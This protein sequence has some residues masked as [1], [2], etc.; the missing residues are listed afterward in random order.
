MQGDEIDELNETVTVTL[1]GATN[2]GLSSVAGA[3]TGSGTVTDDDAAELSVADV[4]VTEGSKAALT[5][6]LSVAS[7]RAVS[8]RWRT[9]SD[10]DGDH[11]AGAADYTAV[12]TLQTVTIAAGGKSASLE[13]QTTQDQVD[14]ADETFLVQLS[15]PTNAALAEA[16]AVVTITDDDAATATV[17]VG[18]PAAAVT[19][20]DDPAVTVD[21]SFPVTLSAATGRDVVVSYSLGG[22]AAAGTDYTEPDP[23]EVTITAGNATASIVIPVKGDEIDELN[24]T[25]TVTLTGATNA[26]LSKTAADLTGSGTITDDDAAELSVADAS[27]T[28]G[29][30]AALTVRLSVASD[31][32]VSFKWRTAADGDGDHPAGAAD[33]T[34]VTTLQ[35]VTIAAGDKSASLEV[36]TTQDQV[37]EAD[38]TFLV[39]LSSP[40]N[41]ALDAA[42]ATVTI[43]DDDAATA[44]VSVGDATAAVT[45]GDDPAVTVDLSFPVTLSAATGRDV[46]VSYTLGGTAT[47]GTDYAEP[48]PLSVTIAAGDTTANILI[49]VQGDEID[50][51]N[52]T[53]TVTLTGATNAGLSSV[54]GALTGSGTVTDDDAAELSVADVSVTEGSKAALTVSLSVASDRAVSFRWRTA[55][56]GDGDHPA[57]AADYTA[58]TTLQTVTIAAGGKSASLEVQTT[59]DQVDEADETFLVQLSSPTNA[60][61]AEAEAVVTITDDD[62]ATATVSVGDPAAAVTEGDDPAVTVDLSFPVTLS[63]AT[64]RDVVVSYSLGGTAA[65]GTDYTEPDPLEVTITAG[66]ATASIVIPVKGDEIDELNETVTVTLTG[67]TNAGLSSVAGALTGSGTVTDDDDAELSVADA[68]VTEG[69]KAALTVRLS[70]ASDRAVSF[71]WRTAADGDGDH[72]AGAADYTAVTTL[73]TVTIA[74]GD[75][76]ASLEV[77]TT[78]DQ[79][80]EADET[81]LVELSSPTNAALDAAEAT[82]TITDD[83]AATATVSVGDAT[84]AVTEGDDPAVTVDLSF[85]VTLSA[86]TGRDVV[87]SYTL[88]G[89]ATAGTDYAEPDP[90]SVTIAAGDT[91]ANILIPVQGDEIDEL[92][93][94]VTVTLTGATNAGLSSVAGALTG[95]GTVTD[96]DAAELSVADVS[97]T[98]G[99]KAALTVSLSVASDRAVSFRWRTASDGDG[100]HPAGAAD[101]TAV[102]TLQTV[103][104]AAGGKSASLEVQ[105]TQD[106]VDEADETFLVQLSS[107]TNAALAEAEAVVTITDD[108]AATAT[109]SVGDPAAA[110]TEGDDPAVTVDL[111]FPVTLSAATGRDVVVSYSLG[112]TAAAGTDYTEPDPLEV[113]ITAGNATA[114]IVIPVKGDEIDEL[115]ETVTVTLTGATNAGLSSVAGALTGS[116]TVTDDDDAELSV[117]DASAAEGSGA[118]FAVSLSVASDR[119]VSF[120]WK[121]AA[122]ADGD[123]PAGAADYTAVSTLQTVTIAAGDQTA[124][125]TVATTA[126]ELDEEDETFL[127]QLSDPTNASIADAEAVGTITNNAQKKVIII[128]TR[129]DSARRVTENVAVAPTINFTVELNRAAFT[130]DQTVTISVGKD[131]D[132]AKSGVDYTAVKDFTLTLLAGTKNVQGSFTLDPVDDALD[133]ADETLTL[134][135]EL[136]G[137]DIAELTFTIIDDDP[138]PSV[139]VGNGGSVD[140]GNNPDVTTD[141]IFPVTLS[142]V[143]GRDVSATYSLGGTATAGTDYTAPDPLSVTVPAG[144]RAAIILIP[145]KGDLAEEPNETVTV[146]LTGATNATLTTSAADLTGSGTITDD[147]GAALSIGDASAAEGGVASFVISLNSASSQAVTVQWRTTDDDHGAHPATAG[148]DYT[149]VTTPQTA[150]IPAGDLRTVVTVQT[151]QDPLDEADETFKVRLSSP[152]N[153]NIADATATGTITDDDAAP[154]VSVGDAAAVDEGDDPSVTTDMS[155]P[156]SLSAASGRATTVTYSLGGTATAGTDYTAPN[157]LSLTISA[158]DLTADIVIPVKG[159]RVDEPD[160]TITVT[161]TGATNLALSSTAADLT[162]SG[163]ITDNDVAVNERVTLILIPEVIP[164]NGGSVG[165][166]YVVAELGQAQ[167]HDVTLT[168]DAQGIAPTT[169]GDFALSANR[170]LFIK[171]GKTRSKGTVTIAAIDDALDT[172]DKK[173]SVSASLVSTANLQPPASRT[174]TI[175]DDDATA[176]AKATA[177]FEKSSYI[178]NEDDDVIQIT[179]LLD[180][181]LDTDLILEYRLHSDVVEV[182][183][184]KDVSSLGPIRF[185]AGET[186]RTL[187]LNVVDNDIVEPDETFT[188]SL[189]AQPG[190]VSTGAPTT[191]TITDDDRTQ[192]SIARHEGY[193][194]SDQVMEGNDG[195]ISFFLNKAHQDDVTVECVVGGTVV[196]GEDF[197]ATHALTIPAGSTRYSI[198]IETLDDDVPE[199]TETLVFTIMNPGAPGVTID[200]N[201]DEHTINVMDN[202]GWQPP[203]VAPEVSITAGGGITE[204]EDAEFTLTADP[205]P[206]ADVPVKVNITAQGDFGAATGSRTVTVSTSGKATFTVSTTDDAVAES[207]GWIIGTL[208]AGAYYTVSPSQG[209]ATVLVSDDEVTIPSKA[210]ASFEKSSYTFNEDDNV[211]RFNVLLDNALDTD[212]HLEYRL[213]SD[214]VEVGIGKDVRLS[215]PIYFPAGETTRVLILSVVDNDIVEPDETFTLSLVA[216]P[217]LVSTGAP[218]TVTITDDDRTQISIARHEGYPV[219]DQV[220]EGNDGTISFFLNKAHQDDV[221]VE[222]VVGGT[223]VAGEDFVATHALTIPAGSTRYS[224]TIETLDDDV[225]EPTETLVFTIMNPGA[226]GVTIDPKKDEHTINVMDNDG[227]QP[228]PATKVVPEVSI[229]ADTDQVAEG[230]SVTFTIEANSVAGGH[231]HLIYLSEYRSI[232]GQEERVFWAEV[233]LSA[234][235]SSGNT[236]RTFTL[237]IEDDDEHETNELF[238]MRIEPYHSSSSCDPHTVSSSMGSATV[239]V[240]DNDLPKPVFSISAGGDVTEGGNA[241]FTIQASPKPRANLP[242]SVM[243]E[244]DGDYGATDGSR[245]ITVPVSGITSFSVAT[246]D[247]DVDEPD[248]SLAV[249]LTEGK[250]YKVS[251]TEKSVKVAVKDNDL[252]K[253]V[254]SITAGSDVTEGGDVVFTVS[255]TEAHPDAPPGDL[256]VDVTVTVVGDYGVTAESATVAVSPG[257]SATLTLATTDDDGDEVDGSVTATLNAGDDYEVDASQD[258]ATVNVLDNDFP[259]PV[260]SVSAG[261][262]ITEGGDAVFT[263]SATEAHPD[264]PPGDL[265]V[266]VTIA[267]IGDYGVTTESET[268]TVSPG[269]SATLTIAT[270]DDSLDDLEGSITATLETGDGYAVSPTQGTATVNVAD[271]DPSPT[272]S[273]EDASQTEGNFLVFQVTLSE[274][275]G[276]EVQVSWYTLP[277]YDNLDN[278]AH[279][280]D[281]DAN[282]GRLVFAPGVTVMTA[283]VCIKPDDED[284]GDEYFT[285]WLENPDGA[286]IADEMAIMTIM[287]GD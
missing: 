230:G 16:E 260:V 223:V 189:V 42:E 134:T 128:P 201:K 206:D 218:T 161:L 164:E 39:E 154:T 222:C 89:T 84:A 137:S 233:A 120:K 49:P 262:D 204:G 85:P 162:G 202:D 9:A 104:I 228:P 41:A 146:T 2:A 243:V 6:S 121:T 78:Q 256:S 253:P 66:N 11:P 152:T 7:D 33:Y 125:L 132:P 278:R 194:V 188:L 220:M 77:Q 191:V 271:D 266:D 174:L 22:T 200:P 261:P 14:E 287:D 29:G 216:Q 135:A 101:Y 25:V 113:T 232:N 246:T 26:G 187:I 192:I 186:T 97:V 68:S 251:S 15:S 160:E 94:T 149:A 167:L 111:S 93:E 13:V 199:P 277:N 73:Q 65:A 79:V 47:A 247:D 52:E 51:L 242:V 62:A 138:E 122:D 252:P 115:N 107:P 197:V 264:A 224:I 190:L 108:D 213:H 86:A 221:T 141:L 195:T 88:G 169:A 71:K 12:T 87:V 255:A 155:F 183:P 215:E 36:Q 40:T 159:D 114:S 274:A 217:G 280:T 283:Q 254:V 235:F 74:A 139:M 17:S 95:S 153:A 268:V 279:M 175:A 70:V 239:R 180:N 231:S 119:A 171:A 76:S 198:T 8:F 229:V 276:R 83:D 212:L 157:P 225:P 181:A 3:L 81:F 272:V 158:G 45:E 48:D 37:D 165:A 75:K 50:E 72:P 172:A 248:G 173:V 240:I 92:N 99:S 249:T 63:A 1:T 286:T 265:T 124:A 234:V 258:E 196:A 238:I 109:V 110:V 207:N 30:K 38:E 163:T 91:T 273:I 241:Q 214:V 179:V 31:R 23:L 20:G 44:T 136:S 257:G 96:D 269:G 34:A 151:T 4:S 226:P 184:G 43:T 46:V 208:E 131:G 178:F 250:G 103:T 112:G 61:L 166:S 27:V 116:G 21:L 24:E 211:M 67:A 123:H 236:V 237:T 185:S 284:E 54:A 59:Q 145:V 263:I 118:S 193:P 56:D 5:V 143:S 130:T 177:T 82:V 105:T 245:T 19:E 106:Q 270:T 133:E 80:D 210:T 150:T 209:S 10:G 285:V 102:T 267:V 203:T 144:D 127:V 117:A 90:L 170:E 244:A 182:G 69:G 140:E 282:G 219:S 205:V 275:S 126:D 259:K 57:G 148:T 176:P 32:A 129:R 100:D 58:V 281:Y 64:G 227:W 147:D 156:V 28:E 168:V 18:D 53:V 55:S 35:T 60:A 98:E 142:A